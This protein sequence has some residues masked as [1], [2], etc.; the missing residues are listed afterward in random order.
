MKHRKANNLTMAKYIRQRIPKG[1]RTA[2]DVGCGTKPVR[3]DAQGNP[4]TMVGHD[5]LE[6]LCSVIEKVYAFDIWPDCIEERKR[7]GPEARYW[8]EDARSWKP[9][10]SYD[11]VLCHHVLEH[12][13]SQEAEDLLRKLREA[14]SRLLVVGGPLGFVD[15]TSAMIERRNPFEEHRSAIDLNLMEDFE[16]I[17]IPP[18]FVAFWS[19]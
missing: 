6:V 5:L 4:R 1:A 2:L 13:E 11:V 12:L 15:N 10:R 14:T 8:V 7:T 16:I 18:A 3:Y 19:I 9:C 17:K